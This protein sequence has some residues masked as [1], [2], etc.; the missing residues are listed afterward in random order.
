ML[1]SYYWNQEKEEQMGCDRARIKMCL[2]LRAGYKLKDLV[3]S[4]RIYFY[5]CIVT[6]SK[7]HWGY[8]YFCYPYWWYLWYYPILIGPI[9]IISLLYDTVFK[10]YQ[11]LF[12]AHW[13]KNK[14]YSFGIRNFTN[15][16]D[17]SSLSSLI[18]YYSL[19]M[20]W[21]PTNQTSPDS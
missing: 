19:V 21:I 14:I 13:V 20:P 7:Q 3:F 18:L 5:I 17:P 15:N 10:T 6:I 1:V 2:G 12:V 11:W 8:Y 4:Y 9:L 16:S